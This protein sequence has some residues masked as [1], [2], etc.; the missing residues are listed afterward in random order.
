MSERLECISELILNLLEIAIRQ[1]STDYHAYK[2]YINFLNC[3]HA[4]AQELDENYKKLHNTNTIFYH[5]CEQDKYFIEAFLYKAPSSYLA[6]AYR[7]VPHVSESKLNP[8]NK[9]YFNGSDSGKKIDFS[10]T[11]G[12]LFM[13]H[14]FG[15]S[16][17]S[18]MCRSTLY[19]KEMLDSPEIPQDLKL[20]IVENSK[21]NIESYTFETSLIQAIAQEGYAIYGF[22]YENHGLSSRTNGIHGHIRSLDLVFLDVIQFIQDVYEMEDI[23]ETV[24]IYIMG[25]SLGGL[26][27]YNVVRKL[28]AKQSKMR[29]KINLTKVIFLT[30]FFSLAADNTPN[31]TEKKNP[32]ANF[33]VSVSNSLRSLYNSYVHMA[34]KV[35]ASIPDCCIRKR[36]VSI[37]SN[38]DEKFSYIYP[39][40]LK[41]YLSITTKFPLTTCIMITGYLSSLNNSPLPASISVHYF[42]VVKDHIVGNSNSLRFIKKITSD[43][44]DAVLSDTQNHILQHSPDLKH[45]HQSIKK[46]LKIN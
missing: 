10:K 4:K 5:G 12:V 13:L 19:P 27:T 33:F 23:P 41:D 14:G 8:I 42:G 24:P 26:I 38:A 30:P 2:D 9:F 36:F 6:A 7:V 44:V 17:M 43:K 29:R 11:K 32:L 40:L 39:L 20:K 37:T 46:F 45:F 22:D 25:H 1:L 15:S 21:K 3:T 28:V 31:E 16:F 34:A 35:V 18:I